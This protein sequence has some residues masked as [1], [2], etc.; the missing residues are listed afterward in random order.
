[1]ALFSKPP[2]KKP[3]PA[4]AQP[5][6]P[7]QK[8]ASRPAVSAREV[9]AQV[10]DR[11]KRA[12][13]RSDPTDV[14][15]TGASIVDWSASTPAP[16]EVA[17]ANPG[18]CNVLE[19]AALMY[20]SGQAP[21]ARTLLEEGVTSD[22]DTRLS[23]LAWLALF[24]LLQRAGDRAAFDQFALQYVVQFERSAP[25]WEDRT[26]GMATE[27]PKAVGGYIAVT[28]RL[29]GDGFGPLEGL[30]RALDKR[31]P[32]AR[33]DLSQVFE[34]DDSG[35][36]ALA[37]LLGRARREHVELTLQRPEKLRAAV[38][39]AVQQGQAGG[40]GAWLL[41]LE[42]L[43]WQHDQAVF[44]DR[45]FEFAMAFERSPPSWEPPAQAEGS[46]AGQD[47]AAGEDAAATAEPAGSD[48]T[49]R[50]SGVLSGTG[51]RHLAQLADFALTR[52]A[53][54]IDM[55]AI[56]RIDFVCAG[57]LLNAINRIE[58]QRKVVQVSGASPI[59]RALLL[60]IGISPRH[61]IRQ[62]T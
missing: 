48:S 30:R 57:A 8:P 21:M 33:V 44:E 26:S 49:L 56:E 6:R 51:Q 42:L 54:T 19:N 5:S 38:E 25:A 7:A 4:P 24:D 62:A 40:E 14:S 58:G 61:F 12:A 32:R 39:A 20:A 3:A 27:A 15:V 36:R 59:I 52:P 2:L 46:E 10:A 35:A 45:A 17:H 37:D 31:V 28:G 16:I 22:E 43:Q 1:M 41:S 13:P 50:W 60:L 23:A 34:F 11:Q 9:A 29:S 18:L 55:S 47:D 53:M